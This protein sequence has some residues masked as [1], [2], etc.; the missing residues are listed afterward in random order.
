MTN[1]ALR[2][3]EFNKINFHNSVGNLEFGCKNPVCEDKNQFPRVVS[4]RVVQL[5]N[6]QV[7]WE[8]RFSDGKVIYQAVQRGN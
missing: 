7:A 1:R 3:L 5:S 2:N 4:K 6:G 8:I